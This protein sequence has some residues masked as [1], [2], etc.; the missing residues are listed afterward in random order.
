[1][2]RSFVSKTRAKKLK[3]PKKVEKLFFL[4]FELKNSITFE[5]AIPDINQ[6]KK[7]RNLSKIRLFDGMPKG[8]GLIFSKMFFQIWIQHVKLHI[9]RKFH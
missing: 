4:I 3:K 8:Q 6:G 9:L 1:V 5:P 7:V 2:F